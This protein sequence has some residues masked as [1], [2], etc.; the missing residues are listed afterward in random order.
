[1]ASQRESKNILSV[2]DEVHSY[3]IQ[4]VRVNTDNDTQ[5]AEP[6][7]APTV[8]WGIIEGQTYKDKIGI[9]FPQ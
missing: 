8:L 5:G 9:S 7:S 2:F 4:T 6:A 1:M 3:G